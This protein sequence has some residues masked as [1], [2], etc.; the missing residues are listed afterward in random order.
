MVSWRKIIDPEVSMGSN[1][2]CCARTQPAQDVPSDLEC[3]RGSEDDEDFE[4][5]DRQQVKTA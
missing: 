1:E 5:Q 3:E 2:V 4:E